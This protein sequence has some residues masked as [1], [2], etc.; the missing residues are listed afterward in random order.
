MIPV[1]GRDGPRHSLSGKTVVLS[2]IFPEV[3]GGK[4][5]SLGKERVTAMLE[6]FGARV[7]S[8]VSGKTDVLLLG[9][10]PG[11]A[12]PPRLQPTPPRGIHA[13]HGCDAARAS[14]G[15]V[16]PGRHPRPRLTAVGLPLCSVTALSC[17]L[18]S[19]LFADAKVSQAQSRGGIALLSLEDVRVSLL[20]GSVEPVRRD[21]STPRPLGCAARTP[22]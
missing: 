19:L 18:A 8:A 1:P 2:G 12:T 14:S 15:G 4:G 10:E 20:N 17:R 5:L 21:P 11:C 16:L 13:A 7:T 6:S 22:N 9:K 3:G